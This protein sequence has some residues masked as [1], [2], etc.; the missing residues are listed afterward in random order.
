[1]PATINKLVDIFTVMFGLHLLLGVIIIHL[2]LGVIIIHL[3]DS[4]DVFKIS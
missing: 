2:L 3:I 1:V 4:T